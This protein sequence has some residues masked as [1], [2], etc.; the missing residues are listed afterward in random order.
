MVLHPQWLLECLGPEKVASRVFVQVSQAVGSRADSSAASLARE[1]LAVGEGRLADGLV[2]RTGWK[3]ADY[4]VAV[5]SIAVEGFAAGSI[6]VERMVSAYT[7]AA[8]GGI[9]G[10]RTAV[11]NDEAGF[12]YLSRRSALILGPSLMLQ[13]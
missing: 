13:E 12:V 4:M 1:Y 2:I 9:A 8:A 6:A 11:E 5:E 3:T 10:T 7:A